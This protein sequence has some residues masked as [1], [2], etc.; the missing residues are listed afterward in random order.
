M[1]DPKLENWLQN[2]LFEIVPQNLAVIDRDH[3]IVAHN[4]NFEQLFGSGVGKQ[5]FEV[6]KKNT[7]RCQNCAAAK[8]FS[9]GKTRVNE[10]KGKDR[11]GRTAHYLVHMV[12]V[13]MD[14]GEIPYIIEMSTDISEIKRLQ[15]EY[16]ILFEKVPCYIAVLNRDHR[17]VRA[18]E[19][20]QNTFGATTGQHCWEIFKRRATRCENCPADLTFSD[21]KTHTREEVGFDK[22]GK[23]TYYIVTTTPLSK[24]IPTNHV[25]EIAVDVNQIHQLERE[26]LDAE[27]LAA[28]GQTVAGLAHGIKNILTG[29]EGG[30]YIFKTGLDKS[31]HGRMNQGWELLERNIDKISS[32]T[33]NLLSFSK[34]QKMSVQS[35]RPAELTGDVVSLFRETARQLDINLTEEIDY[36]IPPAFFDPEGIHSCLSNLVSNAIDACQ[37][38]DR[39]HCDIVVRCRE[40][41]EQIIFEVEDHGCGIDYDVKQKL[42]TNF[43]T[44]KGDR[45]TGLGLLVTRK[46]TQEHGGK[47][48]MQTVPGES[49]RFQMVFPR[50][51]LPKPETN[52]TEPFDNRLVE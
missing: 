52:E 48:Q 8:T 47:I 34:G 5:C 29:L 11:Q 28:V 31:D 13:V 26:K 10:D 46:I 38:S 15:R 42:F 27:R 16:Q 51:R 22:N 43:F 12:P 40:E 30:I 44:T 25:I 37:M 50:K 35:V 32:L 21:G 18:N 24:S 20:L 23:E 2:Q 1:L 49:T 14:D 41:E 39:P 7:T 6:Y 45:G 4:S 36:D 33:K 19:F 17:I 3:K 9:D